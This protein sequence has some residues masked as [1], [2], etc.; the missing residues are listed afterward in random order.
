MDYR[1]IALDAGMIKRI[2][3]EHF[4]LHEGYVEMDHSGVDETVAVIMIPL[5]NE[6]EG[7]YALHNTA[8]N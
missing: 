4:G 6:K 2:I 1:I 3:A 5:N 7:N 8:F